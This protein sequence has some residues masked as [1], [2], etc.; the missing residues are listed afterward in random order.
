M[1]RRLVENAIAAGD[2]DEDL[3]PHRRVVEDYNREDCESASRL[4]EW[5]GTAPGR[6][7]RE[8]PRTP[9]PCG[10]ERRGVGRR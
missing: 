1:S 8:R 3:E 7:N 5:L 6:G 10:G 9:S 2:F 4:R